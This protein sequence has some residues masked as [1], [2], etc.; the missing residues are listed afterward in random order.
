V[1]Y[2]EIDMKITT[3]GS[4]SK[5]GSGLMIGIMLLALV[6]MASATPSITNYTISNTTIVPPQIT[7]IDVEFSEHVRYTIA[8]EN[9]AGAVVRD[10]TSRATNPDPKDWGG[11]YKNGT[12]VPDGTYT[13]IV[14]GKKIGTRG[15]VSVTDASKTIEVIT[16]TSP[17]EGNLEKIDARWESPYIIATATD[18]KNQVGKWYQ[19][20]FY[21]PGTNYTNS[22]TDA[23]PYNSTTEPYGYF[24]SDPWKPETQWEE[25]TYN[26]D[27]TSSGAP[28]IYGEWAVWLFKAGASEN[29]P[30]EGITSDRVFTT[31]DV[32]IPEFSTIALPIATVLGLMLFMSRKKQKK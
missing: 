25:H 12:T 3:N 1:H 16:G 32:P 21:Q 27:V 20:R 28:N 11:T 18:F 24:V 30:N 2:G 7:Y 26:F 9:S 22:S 19:F 15:R 5:I 23:G 6:G 10:W 4:V 29:P 13:V 8:I 14:T 31:V 17:P